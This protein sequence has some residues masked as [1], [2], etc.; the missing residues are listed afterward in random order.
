[1]KL[2]SNANYS[3]SKNKIK[4]LQYSRREFIF[5]Q[6]AQKSIKRD[7]VLFNL[8]RNPNLNHFHTLSCR[9]AGQNTLF[10]RLFLNAKTELL[11]LIFF[12]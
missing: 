12:R 9:K 4:I 7:E 3:V 10:V 1:M 2:G 8:Q 6:C 5:C 11:N